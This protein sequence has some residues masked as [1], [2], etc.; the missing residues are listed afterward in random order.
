MTHTLR[1][2]NKKIKKAQRNNCY[3]PEEKDFDEMTD[4]EKCN[5]VKDPLRNSIGSNGIY[6]H[7]YAQVCMGRCSMCRDPDKDQKHI[8]KH[9]KSE[10]RHIIALELNGGDGQIE[11]PAEMES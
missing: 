9:K 5:F 2:Y 1:I 3:H 10:F 6:Y 8:R 11:E 4:E 7:P